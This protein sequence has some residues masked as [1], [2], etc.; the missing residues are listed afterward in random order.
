M[1]TGR[2][3]AADII[4]SI[5]GQPVKDHRDLVRR[6]DPAPGTSVAVGISRKRKALTIKLTLR[7]FPKISDPSWSNRNVPKRAP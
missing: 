7:N 2:S 4:L 3:A 1:G 6:G 5:N